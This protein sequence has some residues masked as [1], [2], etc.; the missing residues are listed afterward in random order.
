M[1]RVACMTP[2]VSST[3]YRTFVTRKALFLRGGSLVRCFFQ[4]SGD[5]VFALSSG[6][7]KAGEL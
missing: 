1:G 2:R 3:M 5:T 6:Q 7:G 4:D